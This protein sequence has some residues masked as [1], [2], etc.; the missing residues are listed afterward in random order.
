MYTVE[1]IRFVSG[2]ARTVK[3]FANR[4]DAVKYRDETLFALKFHRNT[5]AYTVRI[6][7]NGGVI[8]TYRWRCAA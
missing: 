6:R 2:A 8:D 5:R 1:V 7:Y 4:A 3:H